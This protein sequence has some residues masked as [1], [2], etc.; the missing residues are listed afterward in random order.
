MKSTQAA[1]EIGQ[2]EASYAAALAELLSSKNSA[3]SNLHNR[4]DAGRILCPERD[5][6]NN[7]DRLCMFLL[8][9]QSREMEQ[10]I[11]RGDADV[12]GVGAGAGGVEKLVAKHV[13]EVAALERRWDVELSDLKRNQRRDYRAD[14]IELYAEI[15]RR[16]S[17]AAAADTRPL[18]SN[19]LSSS[20]VHRSAAS[21][22]QL[23]D[24]TTTQQQTS[25]TNASG[26]AVSDVAAAS[27]ALANSVRR[28]AM[29]L[30]KFGRRESKQ[31]VSFLRHSLSL[32]LIL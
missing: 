1:K 5:R 7:N 19:R 22:Q 23:S 9:R 15:Q 29:S 4:C 20:S 11:S 14:V 24:T 18:L 25:P 2:L 17:G 12:A 21:Q 30:L 16:R 8:C 26:G 28:S 3:L 27:T 32:Y 6:N 31:Y 10:L 13:G